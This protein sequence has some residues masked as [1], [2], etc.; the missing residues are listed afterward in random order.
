M[1]F[2]SINA[3]LGD[4]SYQLSVEAELDEANLLAGG[5][6]GGN[7]ESTSHIVV[8]IDHPE[9]LTFPTHGCQQSQF[10]FHYFSSKPKA[11]QNN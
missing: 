9:H 2:A 8:P 1:N 7:E 6:V 4:Q 5:H 3:S 11:K 10:N